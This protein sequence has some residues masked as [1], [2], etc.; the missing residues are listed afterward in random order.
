VAA[1]VASSLAGAVAARGSAAAAVPLRV[2]A[3]DLLQRAG[4]AVF[5]P[6]GDWRVRGARDV[7][8]GRRG[9][10]AVWRPSTVQWWLRGAGSRGSRVRWRRTGD[11]PVAADYD[12]DGRADVAVW[13]P[14]TG[15]SGTSTSPSGRRGDLS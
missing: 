15:G 1:S 9:D 3:T 14:S 11:V 6:A 13:R 8:W 10:V 4:P 12:R 2:P 7:R 5:S